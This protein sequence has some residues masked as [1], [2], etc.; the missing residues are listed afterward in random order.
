[1]DAACRAPGR[2]THSRRR[3]SPGGESRLVAAMRRGVG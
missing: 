3:R 2:L 1:M